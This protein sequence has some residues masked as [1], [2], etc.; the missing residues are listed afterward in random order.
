M[1]LKRSCRNRNCS[2]PM[3]SMGGKYPFD[4][5]K[6]FLSERLRDAV[7][8]VLYCRQNERME[9]WGGGRELYR[10]VLN[11]CSRI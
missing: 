11:P 2:G 9:R 8:Y 5:L 6:V 7:N 1:F 10:E 4:L 3:S